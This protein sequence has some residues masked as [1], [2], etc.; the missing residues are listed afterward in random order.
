MLLDSV[1]MFLHPRLNQLKAQMLDFK[2]LSVRQVFKTFARAEAFLKTHY[3]LNELSDPHF[4]LSTNARHSL[5]E[6]LIDIYLGYLYDTSLK[7]RI[8]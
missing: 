4:F 2:P 3:S 8:I 6:D 1:R 7:H 5:L